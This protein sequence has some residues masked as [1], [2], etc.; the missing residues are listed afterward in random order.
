MLCVLLGNGDDYKSSIYLLNKNHILTLEKLDSSRTLGTL[1]VSFSFLL[2]VFV[3]LYQVS[4]HGFNFAA[5]N[6]HLC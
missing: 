5:F 4:F 6:E 3:S 2:Y 1:A